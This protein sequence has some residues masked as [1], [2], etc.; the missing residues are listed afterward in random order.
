MLSGIW[1]TLLMG[2]YSLLGKCH[3][4]HPASWCHCCHTDSE[5]LVQSICQQGI[6][7]LPVWTISAKEK[8]SWMD[9][10]VWCWRGGDRLGAFFKKGFWTV[11]VVPFYLLNVKALQHTDTM[12]KKLMDVHKF[13]LEHRFYWHLDFCQDHWRSILPCWRVSSLNIVIKMLLDVI[14][15][16][17]KPFSLNVPCFQTTNFK[18]L[19]TCLWL[20]PNDTQQE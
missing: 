7:V 17:V 10:V 16:S 6:W 12:L 20:L 18:N 3:S 5:R 4:V 1:L 8:L 13:F 14:Y 2:L 19:L 15:S 9:L 11:A